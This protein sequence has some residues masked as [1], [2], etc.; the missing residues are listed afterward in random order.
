MNQTVDGSADGGDAPPTRSSAG[1][2]DRAWT[3]SSGAELAKARGAM[4]TSFYAQFELDPVRAI[5][6]LEDILRNVVDHLSAAP[7]AR[8]SSP[9]RSTPHRRLRRSHP[10]SRQRERQPTRREGPGVRVVAG[11]AEPRASGG[12]P[13]G[14]CCRHLGCTVLS[15][16]Q[17]A[18]RSRRS[19]SRRRLD[20]APQQKER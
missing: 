10:P 13:S 15:T 3:G 19:G 12:L 16:H 5:R 1:G 20:C 18:T 17:P 9:S 14:G 4:P 11:S 8:S 6:Q 2:G 7:A